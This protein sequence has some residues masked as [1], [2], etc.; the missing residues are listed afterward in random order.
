VRINDDPESSVW[1]WFGTMSVAPGGRIDVVWLDTRDNPG[2]V[3]SSLYYSYSTDAGVTWSINERLSD[4]FDPHVG[5]PQQNKMGDYFDMISDHTGAHLA[6]AA[7][8]NGEQDVYYGYISPLVGI[9]PPEIA[10]KFSLSRNYPNP[11]NPATTIEFSLSQSGFTTLKIYNLLGEEVA[12]L[13][14]ETL[15]PGL[16]RYQWDAGSMA[17]GIYYY[18]LT[19]GNFSETRKMLLVR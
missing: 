16:Y 9:E 6:W 2:T 11:F 14:F 8:F 18:R 10:E 12:E 1:Q 17:G 3:F 5:W 7:T 13:V 15:S 19:S 4:A